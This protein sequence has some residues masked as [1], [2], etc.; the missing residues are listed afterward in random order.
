[1][2]AFGRGHGFGWPLI[3]LAWG[4]VNVALAQWA[5]GR[6]WG[7]D[8]RARTALDMPTERYACGEITREQ[9][10]QMRRGLQP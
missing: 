5:A 7:T 8:S 1:M 10:E 4:I 3:V 2:G 9:Y 6:S